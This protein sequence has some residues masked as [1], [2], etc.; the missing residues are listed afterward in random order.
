MAERRAKT[1]IT[2]RVQARGGKFLGNDVGGAEVTLRDE[3]TGVLLA[4]GLALGDSGNLQATYAPRA[5]PLT[6]VTPGKPSTVQ[7]LVPDAKTSRFRPQLDLDRPTLVTIEA[8]GPL[9]GLQ[10]QQTVR[11]AQWIVPGEDVDQGPGFVVELPGLVVQALQPATHLALSAIPAEVPLAV[12]VTMMCGCPIAPGKP[13]LPAD[14]DV[15]AVIRKVG[16]ATLAEVP[17]A[18][19]APGPSLFS[20]SYR[21]TK[22]GYYQADLHAIQKST[23][24]SGVAS[25]TFFF[26]PAT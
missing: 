7:W 16:G 12:N 25:V 9:G 13:W 20:G 8:R 26:E 24:N 17:L 3:R 6:I 19:Q 5:S 14:F 1:A 23:G 21:V 22:K 18:F 10:S 11:T 15:R 4:S 2:V